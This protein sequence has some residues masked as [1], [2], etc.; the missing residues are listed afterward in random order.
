MYAAFAH[1]AAERRQEIAVRLAVGASRQRVLMMMLREGTMIAGRGA[2]NGVLV[3]TLVGW[4]AQSMIFGLSSPSLLVS[5]AAMAT[6]LTVAI[7]A[8]WF[9]ALTASR[10]EPNTLLRTD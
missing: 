2:I 6:V 9:P 8:T 5:A 1:S 10:A 4:A 3:A 7:V